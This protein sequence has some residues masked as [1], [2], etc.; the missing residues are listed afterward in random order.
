M[1]KKKD[2]VELYNH[3]KNQTPRLVTNIVSAATDYS[4]I[5][6]KMLVNLNEDDNVIDDIG[7]EE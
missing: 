3:W 6:G 5:S 4:S 2:I 1:T 7:I